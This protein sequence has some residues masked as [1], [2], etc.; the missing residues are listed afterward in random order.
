MD[1]DVSRSTA[2]S[3]FVDAMREEA[4]LFFLRSAFSSDLRD[5]TWLENWLTC[6][7]IAAMSLLSFIVHRATS[8]AEQPNGINQRYPSLIITRY[9]RKYNY[10]IIFSRTKF[11][12]ESLWQEIQYIYVYILASFWLD[13]VYNTHISHVTAQSTRPTQPFIHSGSTDKQ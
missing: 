7:P 5:S 10:V 4:S 3:F 13:R 12:H 1:A 8:F 11:L 9:F 2:A 6:D